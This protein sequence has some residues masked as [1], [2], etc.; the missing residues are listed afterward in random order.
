MKSLTYISILF[1]GMFCSNLF[2]SADIDT[3]IVVQGEEHALSVCVPEN[4]DPGISYPL[5]IGLHY[6]GGNS[7]EYR[8]AL[9]PLCDSLNMVIACPGNSGQQITDPEMILI[10][11]DSAVAICSIDTQ[12]VYLTGMSCNGFSLLQMG[13][14]KIYP[15]RGIFPW[16]PYFSSFDQETFNLDSD[17]PVVISVGSQDS[18]LGPILRLYDS[19]ETHHA[20]VDLEIVPDVGHVLHFNSFANDMIRCIHYLNDTQ[21]VTLSQPVDLQIHDVDDPAEVIISVENPYGL[22]LRYSAVSSRPLFASVSEVEQLSEESIRVFIDPVEGRSG[23]VYFVIEAADQNGT[24]ISQTVFRAEVE[25]IA[26]VL[27][28][29]HNKS[30]GVYPQ[31][32]E[33]FLYITHDEAISY[34]EIISVTGSLLYR[35]AVNA[36]SCK[37]EVDRIPQGSYILRYY[38]RSGSSSRLISI[39]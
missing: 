6:C 18:N 22:D 28:A 15:F 34:I 39:H 33:E 20:R 36:N 13:L 29:G 11:I 21:A 26:T 2:A 8:S 31:P 9:Q 30:P 38:T 19:L 23:R 24:A 17:M 27:E 16:V 37:I 12:Q 32:A 7:E 14:D 1:L 4:Y 25:R 3:A 10:A 35:E 5:I